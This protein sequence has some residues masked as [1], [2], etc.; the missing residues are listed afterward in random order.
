MTGSAK[1]STPPQKESVDCCVARAP[2]NEEETAEA[3]HSLPAAATKSYRCSGRGKLPP[4]HC[5]PSEAIHLAARKKAWIASSQELL[6]MTEY[7]VGRWAPS[8]SLRAQ[9]SNPC[10]RGKK[11]WIAS[12]Q[13]LLAMTR[14][15]RRLLTLSLRPR[16]SPTAA[17]GGGNP[18]PPLPPRAQPPLPPPPKNPRLP[19]PHSSPP[20]PRAT[21]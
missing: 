9:R 2:R 13:E 10:R 8:P 3:T 5:E 15:Q 19:P 4:R 7:R 16:R 20:Y 14:R 12:S 1:Q 21:P 17:R 6:A 18:P 11:A